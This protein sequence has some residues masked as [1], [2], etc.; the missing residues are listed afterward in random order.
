A[1]PA[2]TVAALR[3]PLACA[4]AAEVMAAEEHR[5]RQG[6]RLRG[7]LE[8]A[9][10]RAPGDHR[11]ALINLRRDV[12]NARR[13]RPATLGRAEPGLDAAVRELLDAWLAA[14]DTL[15][16]ALDRGPRAL[17]EDTARA[18]EHARAE[19]ADDEL[20]SAVLLQSQVLE[21]TMDRYLDPDRRFDKSA[22]H[23]ERTLLELLYR[24]SLKTSPFS[25]LTSVGL[26]RFRDGAPGA[27][28]RP[29]DL[30]K[31][32]TVRLNVA[33]LARLAAVVQA[34]P[35]L[36]S[37]F[38]VTL[39]PG[40]DTDGERMRYVRRRTTAGADPDAVVALDTVHE[41]L[42]F[43]P[44]GPV[45]RDVAGLTR[46]VSPTLRELSTALAAAHGEPDTA[47]T[48][49]LLGHLLRLGFLIV[50]DLQV[51]LRSDDPAA[52]FAA[53]LAAQ[54]PEP[55]REAARALERAREQVAAYSR[56]PARERARVLARV[57]AHVAECFAAVD[58][59]P[60]LTPRTL[61]YEDTVFRGADADR[62][63]FERALLGDLASLA[64]L[65]AAFDLNLPRR[66]TAK[67]FFVARY[68]RGGRCD[69]VTRFCH[70]FQRDFFDPYLQR[71]MRRRAFDEGNNHVPQENWFRSAEIAALDRA[72]QAIGTHVGEL[73]A[74][75]RPGTE[76]IRLGDDFTDLVRALLPPSTSTA[77]PWSFLVQVSAGAD[78]EPGRAVVNQAYA[79]LTL[80]FSRF[81]HSLA[82]QGAPDLV[83]RV[84]RGYAPDGAVLAELHGGYET[85]NLN[86]HPAVTD[87][88][89]VCP[90]D[91]SDRP[92][93][94]QIPLSDLF[95]VHDADA[96]RVRLVSRR[97]GREVVPVY[98]GYLMP[99]A[100]PEVQQALLCFSPSGM[101][102]PDLWAGTGIPVPERGVTAYPRLVL[103]DL[104]LQRRMWKMHAADFPRRDPGRGDADFFLRVRRWRRDLGLPERVFAQIDNAA[105]GGGAAESEEPVQEEGGTRR[106]A[107]RKPLPVDFASWHSIQLLEQ[108]VLAASSRIVLTEAFPDTDGLWLRDEHDRPH[109]S[110]L[111]IELY[112]TGRDRHVR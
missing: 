81:A 83:R 59:D 13:P 88:E 26:G 64:D 109:V 74:R 77:Q 105:A 94:E 31:R 42:F 1:R 39:A 12:F 7:A 17:A 111:L 16:S 56:T 85:T 29:A 30:R 36:R 43:L 51:D 78:G 19:L 3:S 58:A 6:E 101:A 68:G 10:A 9:I 100:L 35:R 27:L 67:G 75:A 104:V 23:L 4:W 2:D 15:E 102:R 50:P 97:L 84:L 47:G 96:D 22:R 107:G 80:M 33:V 98:L 60:A 90:G 55:L 14:L 103:G 79:G 46:D 41:D 95:L 69:D 48:D 37:D 72:R 63:A 112:D 61:L 57:R 28:P 54:E 87:Y 73:L 89:I 70:E 44:G 40:A 5:D 92:A 45:L 34:D 32:A 53:A 108:M 38:R 18:R 62:A 65:L 91:H 8:E 99:M 24:A 66:L 25:T 93:D 20:R 82:D 71:S 106:S 110:E 52:S 49:R 86:I 21:R 11:V 76:E